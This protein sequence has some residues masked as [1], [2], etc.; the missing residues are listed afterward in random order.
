MG[1]YVPSGWTEGVTTCD[2]CG[3]KAPDVSRTVDRRSGGP[4]ECSRCFIGRVI[5]EACSEQEARDLRA[6]LSREIH[7]PSVPWS[8][9]YTRDEQGR[10]VRS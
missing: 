8:R 2:T 1:K 4:R 10:V 3:N 9:T 6:E 7:R 5:G